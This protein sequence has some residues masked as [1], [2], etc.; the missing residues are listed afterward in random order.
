VEYIARPPDETTFFEDVI[1]VVRFYGAPILIESNRLDLLRH[2]RKWGLQRILYEQ[3][4]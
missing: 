1:K 2:M 4:G 3:D